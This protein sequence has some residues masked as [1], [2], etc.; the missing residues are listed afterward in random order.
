MSRSF[1]KECMKR[2][3]ELQACASEVTI[4]RGLGDCV[5]FQT[6]VEEHHEG[7]TLPLKCSDGPVSKGPN[8]RASQASLEQVALAST[9]KI[10]A[11]GDLSVIS[12]SAQGITS[13]GNIRAVE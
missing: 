7:G 2:C 10:D 4:R 5:N 13:G 8:I 1:S 11:W 6:I 3:P 12:C 9:V